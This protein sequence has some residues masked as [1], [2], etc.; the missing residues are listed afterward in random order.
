[1]DKRG[2]MPWWLVLMVLAILF[3]AVMS[4]ISGG[5]VKKSMASIGLVQSDTQD[6]ASCLTIFDKSNDKD[7]DGWIDI[8]VNGKDCDECPD[9]PAKHKKN[10]DGSC[11]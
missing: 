6:R 11:D 4:F 8:Q 3:L 10:K 7:G 5:I 2:E 9:N 1:M